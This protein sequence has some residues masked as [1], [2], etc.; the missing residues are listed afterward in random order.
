MKKRTVLFVLTIV[1]TGLGLP[2]TSEVAAQFQGRAV[3]PNDDKAQN[4]TSTYVRIC[5][6]RIPQGTLS[7]TEATLERQRRTEFAFHPSAP[8]GPLPLTLDPAQFRDR[9]KAFVAYSI[10]R[11]IREVLYQEPCY[12]GCDLNKGHESLLDCYTTIHGVACPTCQMLVIF[13]F[14]QHKAGKTAR[15]IRE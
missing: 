8:T 12:C 15:E 5:R 6:A 9:K 1:P 13:A 10:A 2:D 11:R 14:E 4:P 3:A 7:G